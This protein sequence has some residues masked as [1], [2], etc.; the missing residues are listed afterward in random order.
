MNIYLSLLLAL[1]SLQSLG[2]E[3]FSS[4]DIAFQSRTSQLLKGLLA[5]WKMDELYSSNIFDSG[6]SAYTLTRADTNNVITS[7]GK[8]G[9]C[10][11]LLGNASLDAAS[12][13]VLSFGNSDFSI[14]FWFNRTVAAQNSDFLGKWGATSG[15]REWGFYQE[16]TTDFQWN[17]DVSSLTHVVIFT[18]I[19]TS[20][21]NWIYASHVGGT[22]F[23]SFNNEPLQ[24]VAASTISATTCFFRVG[25]RSLSPSTWWQGKIDE[26]GIWNRQLTSNERTQIYNSGNGVTYPFFRLPNEQ[27]NGPAY[28]VSTSPRPQVFYDLDFDSD[29]DDIVDTL[30]LFNLEHLSN[31]DLIGVVLS[32]QNQWAAPAWKALANYYGRTNLTIGVNTNAAGNATSLF[33]FTTSTNFPVAGFTNASQ[34]PNFLPV[35]RSVL[36]AAS[37]HSV[38][39]LVTGSLSSVASL[40]KSSADT[41]SP[42]S[43]IDLFKAKV[44]HLWV[45]GGYW[46]YGQAISDFGETG[47]ND[48]AYVLTNWPPSVP[49]L[50]DDLH[51]GATVY[52]GATVME[53]L[54]ASNPA[55]YAWEKF[56]GNTSATNKQSG[57]SQVAIMP[58][59]FGFSG[60]STTSTNYSR[61]SG[62]GGT[63]YII[64]G[65]GS[66]GSTY[67]KTFPNSNQNFFTKVLDDSSYATAINN[68]II[69]KQSW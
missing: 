44:A 4:S 8:N 20:T 61:M 6:S 5:Y 56:W 1:I 7:P 3:P 21:W 59:C 64:L 32:S 38:E 17:T 60:N 48:S 43:G 51:Q 40:L 45:C 2:A 23:F 31:L 62:Y 14:A 57:W 15:Q 26:L 39:Y 42:L 37:D 68:L 19:P 34:F 50:L 13:N 25:N 63:A 33:D 46:P 67:W 65:G 66:N 11:T 35:Q 49:M 54:N 69:D 27:P 24:T 47:Y 18:N 58:L 30:L 29:C 53:G 12:S 16:G 22:N 55:R 10:Q 52:T 36:A 9:F 41:N 28:T